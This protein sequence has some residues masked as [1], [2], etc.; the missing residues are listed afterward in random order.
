LLVTGIL[1]EEQVDHCGYFPH[2]TLAWLFHGCIF[3]REIF[4]FTIS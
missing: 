3:H 1:K 2:L 4:L